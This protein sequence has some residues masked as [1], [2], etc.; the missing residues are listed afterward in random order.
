MKFKRISSSIMALA[1]SLSALSMPYTT[2]EVNE[3]DFWKKA[4]NDY[5][6]QDYLAKNDT[7]SVDVYNKIDEAM[8]ELWNYDGDITDR[9]SKG[10]YYYKTGIEY[11]AE[12]K[13]EEEFNAEWGDFQ[14]AVID[15][16]FM[17]RND[18]PQAYFSPSV[19]VSGGATFDSNGNFNG[20]FNIDIIVDKEFTSAKARA[21]YKKMIY[22][23]IDGADEA[24]SIDSAYERTL[25]LHD[26]LCRDMNYAFDDD[27]NPAET[28]YTNNIIGAVDKSI[29]S[30]VCECY[31]KTLE[32]L[33]NYYG[34]ENVYA[35]GW[36]LGS[37]AGSGGPHAWNMVKLEDGQYYGVD[38]TYDDGN[39]EF[40]GQIFYDYFAKGAESDFDDTHIPDYD[41]SSDYL[42]QL[43]DYAE[44]DFSPVKFSDISLSLTDG[45]KI[46]FYADLSKAAVSDDD[47]VQFTSAGGVNQKVKLAD[48]QKVGDK[49]K[50]SVELRP[51]QM[52][53]KIKAQFIYAATGLGNNPVTYS[54]ADYAKS[55]NV[56]SSA[57]NLVDSMM[58]Y[59][60]Y[61][62]LYTGKN[63][64]TLNVTKYPNIS[65]PA[66]ADFSG[67]SP[68]NDD[69]SKSVDVR[70][71]A[72]LIGANTNIRVKF[73][74]SKFDVSKGMSFTC[75]G[76]ALDYDILDSDTVAVYVKGILPQELDD[77]FE[78]NA[79]FGDETIDFT[80]SPFSYMKYSFENP[81]TDQ[82]VKNLLVA[83]Y[84]YNVAASDYLAKQ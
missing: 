69:N 55:G 65:V 34:V 12:A 75:S 38:A 54:A 84:N 81:D 4:S 39:D 18:H 44:T 68:V 62:Q 53:E 83:M 63:I 78:I 70:S 26:Y 72:L 8:Q 42:Y 51:D 35:T 29:N 13:T 56:P 3:D 43:P 31:S 76:E 2:A 66:D 79:V 32:L 27:G 5:A 59:G 16:Y 17:Y 9:N 49:Y 41:F 58:D 73:D 47:Y 74:I 71:A 14:S 22:S 67:Y 15:L 6:Y 37:G 30:G 24:E 19:L 60:A 64:G 52:T 23:F 48:A 11:P 25:Y 28:Y 40:S 1:V 77:F 82:N 45:V 61:A 36:G 57:Q 50:F 7:F 33:L 21:D 80:Y 20:Y 10:K 46:N